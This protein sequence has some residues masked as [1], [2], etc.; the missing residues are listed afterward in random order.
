[1]QTII[2]N[3]YAYPNI[4]PAL[5]TAAGP[6]LSYLSMFTYGLTPEGGLIPLEDGVLIETVRPYAVGP[7]MVLTAMNAEGGFDNQMAHAVFQ[8]A[9][10]S[11]RLLDEVEETI[12]RKGLAG[13]DF[14]FEYLLPEDAAAYADL[15]RRAAERLNPQGAI[16]LVAAAPKT[17]AGQPGLLYEAHDYPKLGAAANLILLMTYEWGYTYGPPMAVA[18]LTQVRRVLD[19]GVQEIPREKILMGIPNYGYDW[20]LPFVPGESRAEK[21]SNP[22]AAARALRTGAAVQWDEAAQTPWYT[23]TDGAGRMHEV[24]FENEASLRA[25]L[26]L[27]AEYDL[28]GVSYWNLMEPMIGNWGVQESLYLPAKQLKF[29]DP[30]AMQTGAAAR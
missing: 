22:E 25:K 5:L 6:H 26:N 11:A 27:V 2:V 20:T 28:A 4:R 23:Y 24:W 15:I 19:Y 1:M 16:V 18:P 12:R 3:G 13:I 10:R 9:A 29:A 14:D 30:D 17:Y 21:V 8:D 7:L